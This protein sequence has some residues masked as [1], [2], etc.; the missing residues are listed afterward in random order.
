MS[1]SKSQ[2]MNI[3]QIIF[4]GFLIYIKNL[5]PL[6]RVMMFPVFGQLIGVFLILYPTY[7]LTQNSHQVFPSGINAGNVLQFF[8]L[9]IVVITPGFFIFLKAFWDYMVAM[10]S[11]NSMIASINK[12]GSLK[13]TEM[14]IQNQ[15]VKLR[16][17]DYI[18]LV[19]VLS[20]IWLLALTL[21]AVILLSG[22]NSATLFGFVALEL[23]ALF[24]VAIVSIYLSLS[25]QV[26]AFET[27]SAIDVLKK[28]WR[29]VEGNFWRTFSLG[30]IL[31]IITSAI[32]PP[33]FQ[34][35]LDK[36]GMVAHAIP[37]VKAYTAALLGNMTQMGSQPYFSLCSTPANPGVCITDISHTV[38]LTIAGGLIT[39]LMLPLGSACYTFLYFDIVNRK[40]SKK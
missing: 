15:S 16:S 11:L 25:F 27:I 7:W 33:I 14:K 22:I 38:V 31:F 5:I 10:V 37:P 24:I 21:P 40:N 13:L 12:Q 20:G 35:L 6:S 34:I 2:L 32:V 23:A 26:F 9:L 30:I 19:L 28:S 29:L 18:L 1:K 3:F 8:L 36:T 17:K 39:S 4:E